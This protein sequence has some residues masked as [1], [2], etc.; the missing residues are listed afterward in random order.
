MTVEATNP[1]L[2][3][4]NTGAA[5]G[6][7]TT[8]ALR[9]RRLGAPT[10]LPA[11]IAR[12]TAPALPALGE[13]PSSCQKSCQRRKGALDDGE[14]DRSRGAAPLT[15]PLNEDQRVPGQTGIG[16]SSM[17]RREV[18]RARDISP[19]TPGLRVAEAG[20]TGGHRGRPV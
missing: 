11:P 3:S 1:F 18:G 2:A 6:K 14:V 17:R 19:L 16:C 7:P 10:A 4:E 8:Y 13:R 12:P 20:I 9:G 15:R 5:C